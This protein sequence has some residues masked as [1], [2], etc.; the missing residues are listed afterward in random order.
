MQTSQSRHIHIENYVIARRHV[1]LEAGS[2]EVFVSFA[3][4]VGQRVPDHL[5]KLSVF[6]LRWGQQRRLEQFGRRRSDVGIMV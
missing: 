1:L 5:L 3:L 4:R 6:Q 2:D